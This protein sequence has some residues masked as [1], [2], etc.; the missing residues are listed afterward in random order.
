MQPGLGLHGIIQRE[1][2]SAFDV[3]LSLLS[4]SSLAILWWIRP[5][6]ECS[7]VMFT[8]RQARST[9]EF[10]IVQINKCIP[11]RLLTWRLHWHPWHSIIVNYGLACLALWISPSIGRSVPISTI[12]GFLIAQGPELLVLN[13]IH[14]KHYLFKVEIKYNNK[15]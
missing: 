7:I 14:T 8:I 4:A 2:V 5:L 6:P 10:V 11:L 13:K 12:F 15:K 9:P 1:C 3:W